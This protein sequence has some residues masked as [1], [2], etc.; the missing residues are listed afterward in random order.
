MLFEKFQWATPEEFERITREA[1]RDALRKAYA[2][3]GIPVQSA[4]SQ[5]P[6]GHQKGR[7]E[8][9]H[10]AVTRK[11]QATGRKKAK[12]CQPP[13]P[14]EPVTLHF[15]PKNAVAGKRPQGRT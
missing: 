15:I 11:R 10:G 7:E 5:H 3:A 4:V 12:K 9:P 8:L 2:D 13:A 1:I 14:P 6:P